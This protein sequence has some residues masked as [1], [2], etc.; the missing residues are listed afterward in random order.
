MRH[1]RLYAPAALASLLAVSTVLADA[2]QT[3]RQGSQKSPVEISLKIGGSSYSSNEP[4]TCAHAPTASIYGVLSEM[5]S[6]RQEADGRSAQL[7]MWRSKKDGEETFSLSVNDKK[8]V[9]VSTVRGGQVTGSG[10]IKLQPSGKGGTFTI[11]AKTK[12]GETVTGTIVCPAFT[13]ATAEGG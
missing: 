1:H 6:V 13:P 11:D 12:A 7:T 10:T 3:R 4:G 8:T 5:W 9:S 2:G